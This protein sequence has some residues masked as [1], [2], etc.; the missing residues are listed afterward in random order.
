[1]YVFIS[2][3][4]KDIWSV[5]LL[6]ISGSAADYTYTADNLK[7]QSHHTCINL[8]SESQMLEKGSMYYLY[9]HATETASNKPES[10]AKCKDSRCFGTGSL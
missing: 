2:V 9:M 7:G 5:P 10:R 3:S 8:D 4:R 1:V 6:K